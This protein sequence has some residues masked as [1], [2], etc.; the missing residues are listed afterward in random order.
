MMPQLCVHLFRMV[1]SLIVHSRC[2]IT[3]YMHFIWPPMTEQLKLLFHFP[4][5]HW[6]PYVTRVVGHYVL[7]SYA[8]SRLPRVALPCSLYNAL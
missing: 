1:L 2:I 8:V 3:S 5:A 7:M 6:I 4:C